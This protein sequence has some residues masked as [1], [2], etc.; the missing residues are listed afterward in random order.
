MLTELLILII[1]FV[2]GAIYLFHQ[3]QVQKGR[4]IYLNQSL[5]EHHRQHSPLQWKN[6]TACFFYEP[7]EDKIYLLERPLKNC[8]DFHDI[9]NKTVVLANVSKI[10]MNNGLSYNIFNESLK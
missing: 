10:I 5:I 1:L 3:H 6:H 9:T 8:N 2:G 4:N 7:Y